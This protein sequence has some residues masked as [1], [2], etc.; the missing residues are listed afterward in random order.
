MLALILGLPH[1]LAV[2]LKMKNALYVIE[3]FDNASGDV[4]RA[5]GIAV[6]NSPFIAVSSLRRDF[7]TAFKQ[8]NFEEVSTHGLVNVD[9]PEILSLPEIRVRLGISAMMG[10]PGY[11]CAFMRVC[12]LLARHKSHAVVIRSGSMIRSKIDDARLAEV[13][14]EVKQLLT[15]LSAGGSTIIR[16][17]L[18]KRLTDEVQVTLVSHGP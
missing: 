3:N 2:A 17:N 13:R 8:R 6:Q 16:P 12:E 11:I 14:Y 7:V 1:S 5:F 10:Y 18:V 9:F 15:Q 4:V